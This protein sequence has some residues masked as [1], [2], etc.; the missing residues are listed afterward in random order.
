MSLPSRVAGL[1]GALALLATACARELSIE[2]APA[3]VPTPVQEIPRPR[4]LGPRAGIYQ[5]WAKVPEA[6]AIGSDLSGFVPV[7]PRMPMLHIENPTDQPYDLLVASLRPALEPGWIDRPAGFVEERC[8]P[9]TDVSPAGLAVGVHDA[10]SGYTMLGLLDERS[11]TL[12]GGLQADGGLVFE[13]PV[14]GL[15]DKLPLVLRKI[16]PLDSAI[17]G[18]YAGDWHVGDAARTTDVAIGVGGDRLVVFEWAPGTLEE[19]LATTTVGAGVFSPFAQAGFFFGF[20]A[21]AE[22]DASPRCGGLT[23]RRE[24]GEVVLELQTFSRER[25]EC[26]HEVSPPIASFAGTRLA[27]EQEGA[28]AA[29]D[30][31]LAIA[32]TVLHR[33]C[34]G[35]DYLDVSLFLDGTFETLPADFPALDGGPRPGDAAA[36]ADGIWVE[37]AATSGGTPLVRR[38]ASG[39]WPPVSARF[40]LPARRSS[41]R[42]TGFAFDLRTR[43]RGAIL[44]GCFAL[45]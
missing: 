3:P 32:S 31:V 9:A 6:S 38:D 21:K 39:A 34:G 12:E 45:P 2:E 1:V 42:L 25:F 4:F 29:S 16:C 23:L 41:I 35:R 17:S 20:E 13:V 37:L 7:G 43:G 19:A 8:D 22:A 11:T 10:A 18:V 44:P 28:C 33:S 15:D 36:F 40:E 5:A 26:D 24:P 30:G 27:G 14:C